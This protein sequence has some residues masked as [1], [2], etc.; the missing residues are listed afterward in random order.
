[1]K[2]L[3]LVAR[4]GGVGKSTL[5]IN[6]AVAA[7]EAGHRVGVIDLDPQSSLSEWTDRRTAEEPVVSDVK[8]N[9]L[10]KFITAGRE[11]LGLDLMF[12]DTPPASSDEMDAAILAADYVV[13]P[14]QASLFDLRAVADTVRKCKQVN[15]P[16]CVIFNR[17]GNRAGLG[18]NTLRRQLVGVGMPVIDAY[19][20]DRVAFK[21]SAA[22]GLAVTEYEPLGK[23][24]REVRE[25][26]RTISQQAGLTPSQAPTLSTQ[27]V[28]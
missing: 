11:K 22:S 10:P 26:F 13:I 7:M 14:T 24:A 17:V 8:V 5:S 21:D 3:S 4:K 2:V 16:T 9:M 1:M 23:A 28:A 6:L 20:F 19:I 15:K 18:V 12:V 25:V 27:K